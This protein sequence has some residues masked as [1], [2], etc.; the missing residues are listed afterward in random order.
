MTSVT[1]TVYSFRNYVRLPGLIFN[2]PF[3]IR[4][5][6][7][8]S[9]QWSIL[10]ICSYE[11]TLQKPPCLGYYNACFERHCAGNLATC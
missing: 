2:L 8:L 10:Y 7:Y 6:Y 5:N 4:F 3:H 1:S 11:K 9:F